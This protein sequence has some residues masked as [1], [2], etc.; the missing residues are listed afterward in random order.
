MEHLEMVPLV[1]YSSHATTRNQKTFHSDRKR[2]R[3]LQ[4]P[5]AS[6]YRDVV[7]ACSIPSFTS[8]SIRN[9]LSDSM[10][11]SY[12]V[13]WG[14]ERDKGGDRRVSKHSTSMRIRG[15]SRQGKAAN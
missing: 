1:G 13:L 9:C 8:I 11:S 4:A 5:S 14:S 10:E 2:P 3:S 12:R 6:L 7:Q 15:L